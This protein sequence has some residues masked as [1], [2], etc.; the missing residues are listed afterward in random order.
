[1]KTQRQR[2]MK[3]ANRHP[4]QRAGRIVGLAV[5]LFCVWGTV[6]ATAESALLDPPTHPKFV[7]PLPISA[8]IDATGGGK[9]DMEMRETEQW[10]V[11]SKIQEETSS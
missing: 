10:F 9:F 2:R 3:R 8:R 5:L 4:L 1:M 7:N 11:D 6:G